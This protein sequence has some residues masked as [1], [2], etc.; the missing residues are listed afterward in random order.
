MAQGVIFELCKERMVEYMVLFSLESWRH[1]RHEQKRLEKSLVRSSY[2]TLL[3]CGVQEPPVLF[4]S[5]TL[6]SVLL[7]ANKDRG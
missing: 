2:Y 3:L 5:H 1:C 6:N 4:D 7:Y